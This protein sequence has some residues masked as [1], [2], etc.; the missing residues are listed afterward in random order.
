MSSPCQNAFSIDR[1][2]AGICSSGH[3]V[4]IDRLDAV[5]LPVVI[6][7]VLIHERHDVSFQGTPYITSDLSTYLTPSVTA[8]PSCHV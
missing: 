2:L 4:L 1:P 6:D 8:A 3:E 7:D 5:R